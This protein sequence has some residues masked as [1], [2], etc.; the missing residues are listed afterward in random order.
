[1][2]QISFEDISYEETYTSTEVFETE[3]LAEKFI[4]SITCEGYQDIFIDADGNDYWGTTPE[5]YFYNKE[6]HSHYSIK[7]I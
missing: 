2:F 1:M 5:T 7:Q 3:E 6:S 4:E